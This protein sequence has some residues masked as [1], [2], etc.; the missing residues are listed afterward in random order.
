LDYL[1][2]RKRAGFAMVNSLRHLAAM[3]S[4][5]TGELPTWT[6]RA[7]R[8]MVVCRTDGTLAPCYPLADS[9]GD[10]GAAGCPRLDPH[11]LAALK[12][13]CERSCYST[14]A[15]ALADYYGVRGISAEV[16]ARLRR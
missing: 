7:G 1:A 3:K 11:R 13:S 8:N 4:L 6:C 12:Q 2:D 5:L 9:N 10:W 15:H 14:V 16:N